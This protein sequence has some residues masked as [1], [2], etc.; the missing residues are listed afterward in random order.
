MPASSYAFY[1]T[2]FMSVHKVSTKLQELK[3]EVH[4]A[5]CYLLKITQTLYNRPDMIK[6][7]GNTHNI[8]LAYQPD[9]NEW[10]SGNYKKQNN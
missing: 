7:T 3:W 1:S 5:K 6:T 9:H 4:L 8:L 10:K 2:I